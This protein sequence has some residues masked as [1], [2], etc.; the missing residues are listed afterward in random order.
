MIGRIDSE[1]AGSSSGW[2]THSASTVL[3]WAVSAWP[4]GTTAPIGHSL[5]NSVR[6]PA[7]AGTS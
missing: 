4:G 3:A 1:G 5:A 7:V 6:K 2:P